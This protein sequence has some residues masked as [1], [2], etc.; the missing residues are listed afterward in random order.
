[1]VPFFSSLLALRSLSSDAGAQE[2]KS[3]LMRRDE[4]SAH[5]ERGELF[6]S[7]ENHSPNEK[8][9]RSEHFSRLFTF[10]LARATLP[11]SIALV[12][13]F[14]HLL[15]SPSLGATGPRASKMQLLQLLQLLQFLQATE[16]TK[17]N[18]QAAALSREAKTV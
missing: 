4:H 15:L 11:L 16:A 1:M 6:R 8:S 17:P 9:V 5:N 14:V 3:L 7:F 18:Q 2:K 13:S 10:A 12:R